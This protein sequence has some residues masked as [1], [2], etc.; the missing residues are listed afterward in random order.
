MTTI[1][2][3]A[4]RAGVSPTTVSYV[5]NR[6]RFVTEETRL[7]VEQ[8]IAE[9]GYRPNA[10]ARSLRVGHTRTLGLILPD[11]SNPFFAEIAH[12]IEQEAFSQGYSII[13]CN[14]DGD[15][16]KERFY[17]HLLND[18]QVD[19][20][21]L[22]TE[23]QTPQVL[24]AYL[25]SRLPVILVDRDFLNNPFDIVLAD[26]FQGAIQA[27]NHL[28]EL[29]HQRIAC[30]AGP[31]SLLSGI[32]RLEGYRQAM[33]D[34]GLEVAPEWIRMGTFRVDAGRQAARQLLG[35]PLPP[36]AIFACNDMMAIGT[37]RAAADLG[38]QVPRE[39]SVIGFDDVEIA[40]YTS[41]A[42]T[43]MAQEKVEICRRAVERL[44]QKIAQPN[45]EGTRDLVPNRLILRESTCPLQVV[46]K[47]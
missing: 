3:V 29:G 22:D 7:R 38:I 4:K 32:Q 24:E 34:A 36:T 5:I 16:E 41:P 21:I 14:T 39:L 19:G 1:A 10:L 26:S 28:I 23:A 15:I 2:E 20:V 18:K 30:I 42:L 31:Q 43:T 25:P 8:A 11:S 46:S 27:V 6:K 33:Q 37:L 40:G 12:G 9:L 17:I 47:T 45:G 44:I 13:L 35:L